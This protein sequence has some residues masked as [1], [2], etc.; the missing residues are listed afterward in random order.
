MLRS[1][2]NRMKIFS[3]V[4][5]IFLTG[6]GG[7]GQSSD[8]IQSSDASKEYSKDV[9]AMDT[10]MSLTAYGPHGEEA[11][12]AAVEEINRLDEIWSVSSKESEVYRINHKGQGHLSEDSKELLT[13][14][15][16]LYEST[17]GAFDVTV[18]PLMDLWGFTSGKYH[19]PYKEEL[20]KT[21]TQ[22]EQSRLTLSEDGYLTLGK[23]Q[24]I[25]L[26]GIAK[27]YTSGRIM[28]IYKEYGVTS[29]IVSLGGNVQA[30]GTKNDGSYWSIGIQD[31]ES[32]EGDILGVLSISDQAVITSGGYERYFE[33]DGE[34]YHHILDPETGYPADSGLISVS[35]I[36]ED[37]TLADGLSTA[38]FVM[39]KEKA[40]SYWQQH[41]DA[42]DAILVEE[43]GS[44]YVTEGLEKQFSSDNSYEIIRGEET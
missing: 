16:D 40:V 2:R 6:C 25:D 22:V 36:S 12:E 8:G 42:F 14:A 18:Y 30:L 35:I 23:K 31:P 37:G 5:C 4:I 34:T 20:S 29:G 15:R 32:K 13:V 19:V 38:L 3:L 33:E 44:I 43:D 7:S 28:E 24:Q 27:G 9:F 41:K 17:E 10:Y 39:G 26:G 1:N 11:V 21:L